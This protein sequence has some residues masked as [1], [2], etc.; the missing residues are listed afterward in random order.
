MT[1]A[2]APTP[3]KLTT[4]EVAAMFGVTLPTIRRWADEGRIPCTRTLGGDR[5][6][7][8]LAVQRKLDEVSM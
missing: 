8:A 6:F 5:R 2:T 7:D 3:R 4:G 1:T